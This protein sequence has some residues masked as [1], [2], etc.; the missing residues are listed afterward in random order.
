M[1]PPA[2]AAGEPKCCPSLRTT[3]E[4]SRDS[5]SP[6]Q[7]GDLAQPRPSVHFLCPYSVT[8]QKTGQTHMQGQYLLTHLPLHEFTVSLSLSSSPSGH[9][10]TTSDP[11]NTSETPFL[12]NGERC[13]QHSC[14]VRGHWSQ[15]AGGR[16]LALTFPCSVDLGTFLIS[17]SLSSRLSEK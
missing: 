12:S 9:M 4:S 11:Q 1:L 17:I 7:T 5:I 10:A 14:L 3:K 13:T 2:Y 15:P 16:D 6:G 8:S